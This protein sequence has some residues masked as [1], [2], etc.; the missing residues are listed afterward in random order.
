MML[1]RVQYFAKFLMDARRF[2]VACSC[3]Y[4]LI[5]WFGFSVSFASEKKATDDV[6]MI[7]GYDGSAWYPYVAIIDKQIKFNRNSW[8]KIIDIRDPVNLTRQPGT[9]D[10]Y[11]K[12]NN[13]QLFHYQV[14]SKTQSALLSSKP[15][16]GLTNNYTQLRAHN[17][18]VV[19]VE[20]LAGKSRDTQLV[21][22]QVP[23]AQTVDSKAEPS[24]K[25][26]VKQA[27]AQF[28]PLIH[29]RKLFYAHVSCRLECDPLIMEVWQQDL[30]TG[31]ARQLTLLNATSYLHSVNAE[32]KLGFLSS[33]QR[34]Y[35]HLAQLDLVT[36]KISWLTRGQ[37]TDSFPG[38]SR[39]GDLYFIRRTPSGTHLMVL[40]KENMAIFAAHSQPEIMAKK[41]PLPEGVQ[42]IRYLEISD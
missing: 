29:Q 16:T 24:F 41:I 33:N 12:G 18:G 25:S 36:Q 5:T 31:N 15:E 26:L 17:D 4:L 32:G 10:Y 35:Y 37:V 8:T 2:L 7:V 11:L 42:K 39:N 13:G 40:Q 28:Y 34:G 21:S 14:A 19:M 6:L 20:L 38:V 9:G 1:T 22:M 3:A 30:N 23:L 27:S